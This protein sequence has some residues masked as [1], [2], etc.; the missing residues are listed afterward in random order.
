MICKE[1]GIKFS[2][3]R[4]NRRQFCSQECKKNSMK[5]KCEEKK[6]PPEVKECPRCSTKHTKNGTFCSYS[7]ANVRVITEEEKEQ[8]RQTHL[9][10]YE[11]PEGEAHKKKIARHMLS[12]R[13][14]EK[15]EEVSA[16]DYFVDIPTIRDQ[17]DYDDF[18]EGYE[19]G[20]NW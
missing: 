9:E 6:A 11:T 1:C 3:V 5:R 12:V 8:R 14:N 15:F 13:N 17:R 19:K 7:C 20:E 16:E 10:Y 2:R 18:F 4:G